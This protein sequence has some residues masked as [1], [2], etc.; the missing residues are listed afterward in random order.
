MKTLILNP[1]PIGIEGITMKD[2]FIRI[3]GDSGNM[4][5]LESMKDE[6][7]YSD[8]ISLNTTTEKIPKVASIGVRGE[9]TA[10][11]LSLLGVHNIRIIGCP[12]FYKYLD[13]KYPTIIQPSLRGV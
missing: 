9:F 4:L 1:L 6:L 12:S 8:I 3:G 2:A 13:G 11:C 5:F 7:E 10:E